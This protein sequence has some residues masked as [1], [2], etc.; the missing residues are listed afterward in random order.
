LSFLFL[1]LTKEDDK[2]AVRFGI[3]AI[4]NFAQSVYVL[5]NSI[6]LQTE[7]N[8][9]PQYTE[10]LDPVL[11]TFLTVMVI[12]IMVEHCD[13]SSCPVKASKYDKSP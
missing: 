13:L 3:A 4:A 5:V 10:V 7:Q 12:G 9:I 6:L 11:Y 1:W 2:A 8:T